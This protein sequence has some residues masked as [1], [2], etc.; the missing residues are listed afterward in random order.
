[1]HLALNVDEILR[2]IFKIPSKL[3]CCHLALTC[4]SFLEPALDELWNELQDGN[5]LLRLLPEGGLQSIKV[6]SNGTVNAEG[7]VVSLREYL[8]LSKHSLAL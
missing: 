8:T 7:I 6:D 1:M 2:I 5:C 4:K 3:D